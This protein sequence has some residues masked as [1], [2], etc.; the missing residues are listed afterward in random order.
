MLPRL[1]KRGKSFKGACT[2]I[3]NDADKKKSSDRVLWTGTLNLD[4][5]PENAWREMHATWRDRVKLKRAAGVDLRGRDNTNPVLHM[6]LSWHPDDGPSSE[7]MKEA[8]LSA[9]KAIGLDG[10]QVLMAAHDDKRHLH[11]HLII[12]T[13]DPTNGRTAPMKY[14]KERLS[15]W[16][17]AYEK[18]HGLRIEQRVENN[19]RRDKLKAQRKRNAA[20][21]LMAAEQGQPPPEAMPYVPV[22]GQSLNRAQWFSHQEITAQ[23]EAMRARHEQPHNHDRSALAAKHAQQRH[24]IWQSMK[25][26]INHAHEH[27]S[28]ECRPRW[29]ELYQKQKKEVAYL[30]NVVVDQTVKRG[31]I[32]SAKRYR[33]RNILERAIFVYRNRDRLGYHFP[34]SPNEMTELIASPDKLMKR[35]LDRQD[36]DRR[37]LGRLQRH[38]ANELGD[39]IKQEHRARMDRLAAQHNAERK[40]LIDQQKTEANDR[41]SFK[42]AKEELAAQAEASRA[43]APERPFKRGPRNE[44]V[45]ETFAKEAEN[46]APPAAEQFKEA[47]A[48]EK[49]SRADQIRRDMEEWRKRNRDRDQGRE[50]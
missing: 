41:A 11:M 30:E 48:H 13:V 21:I 16:A 46:P 36:D 9:L 25:A 32:K 5:S 37:F 17:E 44:R 4:G 50:L 2:Y 15:R 6:T 26:A 49:L 42:Q 28:N 3:L 23:M 47:A 14:T 40:A 24:G 27:V 22:K 7:H 35:V 38:R 33:G 29:R 43:P 19:E 34:L 1:H 20:E 31:S 18:E 8:S 39:V 12:N 45:S 10:H